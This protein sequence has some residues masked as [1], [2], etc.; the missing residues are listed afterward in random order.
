MEVTQNVLRWGGK[1]NNNKKKSWITFSVC[2]TPTL[3]KSLGV[4]KKR[5]LGNSERERDYCR[6]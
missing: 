3:I 1:K 2:S 5:R 4:S 6:M